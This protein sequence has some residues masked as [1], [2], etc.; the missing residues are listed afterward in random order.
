MPQRVFEKFDPPLCEAGLI[1]A[2]TGA[3]S[4]RCYDSDLSDAAW[5]WIA[6]YLQS[7]GRRL[8]HRT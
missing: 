1:C 7:R 3:M 6:P 8:S 5:A 2:M 4:T